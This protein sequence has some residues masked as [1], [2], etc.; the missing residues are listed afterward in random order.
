V[1]LV[2]LYGSLFSRF[3]RAERISLIVAVSWGLLLLVAGLVAPVYSTESSASSGVTTT[4]TATLVQVNGW[5]V[6]LV[7]VVP[8]LCALLV[9]G[10][11]R[12]RGVRPGAGPA[13]WAVTAL[14]TAFNLLAMASIGLFVL[15]VT[16]A[17]AVACGSHRGAPALA[18]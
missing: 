14:L 18:R 9:G 5:R 1:I 7:I 15:P 16:A 3:G 8:L 12:H 13:A 2:R 17:L 10:L 6:L 4:G 11:L